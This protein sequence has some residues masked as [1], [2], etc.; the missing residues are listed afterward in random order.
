MLSGVVIEGDKMSELLVAFDLDGTLIDSVPALAH[1]SDQVMIEMGRPTNG[2]NNVRHWIGNGA[3]MLMA[4]SLSVDIVPDPE[5]D[6]ELLKHARSRFDYFY[7]QTDHSLSKLY[8][9]VAET[10]QH[11]A[12]Q[13]ITMALITNKPE[14]FVPGILEHHQ[15]ERFFSDIIGGDTL[16]ERKP[17]PLALNTLMEKFQLNADSI[18]MVGDSQ[19]DIE[20]AK[21]AGCRSIGLTYGY[22]YGIPIADSSPNHVVDDIAD[23]L[24]HL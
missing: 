14:Q 16:P 13:D 2:L 10:L 24:R 6:P 15:L 9:N 4:R 1:A 18:W 22:N 20:S 5:L 11:L 3:D 21:A 7:A 17:S 8:P 23:I 19:N 12:E